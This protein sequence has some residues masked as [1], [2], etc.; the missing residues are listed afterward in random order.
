M[1]R[2]HS[3]L[4]NS[5][6]LSDRDLVKSHLA[7]KLNGYVGGFGNID[8]FEKVGFPVVF[9]WMHWVGNAKRKL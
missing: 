6:N 9:W 4:L 8:D 5:L 2:N 7:A 3:P 1:L